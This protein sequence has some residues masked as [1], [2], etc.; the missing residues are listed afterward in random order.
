M[1]LFE[2]L[3]QWGF[4]PVTDEEPTGDVEYVVTIHKAQA[5]MYETMTNT[6][7]LNHDPNV[8][9]HL[10]K[11]LT[12][13][14]YYSG[15][16]DGIIDTGYSRTVYALQRYLADTGRYAGRYDGKLD[17]DVSET[18]AALQRWGGVEDTGHVTGELVNW[19][20]SLWFM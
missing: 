2:A 11:Y 4:V 13:R 16:V 3:K 9:K 7:A 20:R 15:V 12:V 17:D 6:E 10:Q 5:I 8:V 1:D 18:V 14:G 19:V